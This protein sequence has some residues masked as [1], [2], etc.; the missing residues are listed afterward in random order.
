MFSMTVSAI[1]GILWQ[2]IAHLPNSHQRN[3]CTT[4]H[5][6][7]APAMPL[8]DLVQVIETLRQRISDHREF[9]SQN[10]IRTSGLHWI[11]PLLTALGWDVFRPSR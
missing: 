9:L 5:K 11:D 1:C 3:D 10:E 7:E 2:R 4:F 6:H 8:D